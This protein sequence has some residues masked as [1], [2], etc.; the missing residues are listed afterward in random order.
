[1][2][3]RTSASP[4]AVGM[5]TDRIAKD[6][7]RLYDLYE[8]T[9]GY[10]HDR[11]DRPTDEQKLRVKSSGVSDEVPHVVADQRYGRE[12]VTK[13]AGEIDQAD[14]L[15]ARAWKRLENLYREPY[16][17]AHC[18]PETGKTWRTICVETGEAHEEELE[19]LAAYKTPDDKESKDAE[20]GKESK[21]KRA[22]AGELE[23][24]AIERNQ[25][26]RR[27][28]L[29]ELSLRREQESLG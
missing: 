28:T 25:T 12:Q 14:Q 23:R 7:P 26:L 13:A 1:V 19:S 29:R 18:S 10:V 4:V 2:A 11:K 6:A 22:I 15:L 8:R 16:Q 17:C 21:R 9:Y 24:L 27:F 5:V 3:R 20:Q